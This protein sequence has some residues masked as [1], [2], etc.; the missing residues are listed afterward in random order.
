MVAL[1]S[2]FGFCLISDRPDYS[3]LFDIDELV[4]A[5]HSGGTSVSAVAFLM[6]PVEKLR[7]FIA[8]RQA[9][10]SANVVQAPTVENRGDKD[11]PSV[12]DRLL[13]LRVQ[14]LDVSP[15][16]SQ[17]YL[18]K[19]RPLIADIDLLFPFDEFFQSP[20]EA[21]EFDESLLM[22]THQ[23][24]VGASVLN[25]L[26]RSEIA[27]A[28]DTLGY[29][30]GVD[31][32]R[33]HGPTSNMVSYYRRHA[34][35]WDL[36]DF[37]DAELLERLK[38]DPNSLA[39]IVKMIESEERTRAIFVF[40][41]TASKSRI[42]NLLRAVI[43]DTVS[44]HGHIASLKPAHSIKLPGI[45]EDA[46]QDQ[47]IFYPPGSERPDIIDI[48]FFNLN[49]PSERVDEN[50]CLVGI[51]EALL[52][53]NHCQ[54][55]WLVDP[56]YRPPVLSP[57]TKALMNLQLSHKLGL[58]APISVFD[59]AVPRALV[60]RPGWDLHSPASVEGLASLIEGLGSGSGKLRNALKLV[61]KVTLV[62]R[63][64]L[65]QAKADEAAQAQASQ[66]VA[67]P[68]IEVDEPEPRLPARPPPPAILLNLDDLGWWSEQLDPSR[69]I[70]LPRAFRAAKGFRHLEP[71]RIGTALKLL[72]GDRW[73]SFQGD[74]DAVVRFQEGLKGLYM[75]D[76]WS[77]AERLQGVTGDEYLVEYSDRRLLLD[78][79][80]ASFSS[81][82][83]SN[84][85][86]RIYY[87]YDK[88]SRRVIVGYMPGHLG[89]RK[90]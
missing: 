60:E 58:V 31:F 62:E 38:F 85:M 8:A 83:N 46:N 5:C 14:A 36:L 76:G 9:A 19:R 51:E 72:E 57:R 80:L 79:H 47:I 68:I 18:T 17:S 4:G 34:A 26:L 48:E 61:H 87:T 69:I 1:L 89:T 42:E 52:C 7:A 37:Q 11:G 27:H 39:S 12:E 28:G 84:R 13:D 45:L 88:I 43:S 2:R 23:A 71:E 33:H 70:L 77:N 64:E 15:V 3:C 53:L 30:T 86:I 22:V 25:A 41:R 44:P 82:Y 35:S 32:F 49:K 81:G 56:H 67:L 78:R 65:E 20:D 73:A 54:P 55:P 50:F 24:G 6:D 59:H 40:V 10:A 66:Q 29:S 63:A 16:S 75:H 21:V 74:R 90:F